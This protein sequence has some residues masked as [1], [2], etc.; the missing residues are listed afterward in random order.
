MAAKSERTDGERAYDRWFHSL[1]SERRKAKLRKA[2]LG[3]HDEIPGGDMVYPVIEEHPA[4]SDARHGD[5]EPEDV[6]RFISDQ[7]LRPRL[8]NL[9]KVLGGYADGRMLGYLIFIRKLLGDHEAS[10]QE[11]A[12]LLDLT[13]QAMNNRA[14]QMRK[15][16][17][18]LAQDPGSASAQRIVLTQ[19]ITTLD[20]KVYKPRTVRDNTDDE[21]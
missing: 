3:P 16:L 5:S 19:T 12:R 14:R 21:L 10:M 7:E 11:A 6:E 18:D 15:A 13:P 2:G 17:G 9:F 1:K 20:P 8:A 4:W